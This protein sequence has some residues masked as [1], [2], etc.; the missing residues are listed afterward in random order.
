MITPTAPAHEATVLHVGGLLD[1]T[2]K[3]VVERALGNR[4]GVLAVDANPV[5][6]TATVAYRGGR[7][8]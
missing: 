3:A 8:P 7:T 4:P 6:Q 1:A 2:E 5:A